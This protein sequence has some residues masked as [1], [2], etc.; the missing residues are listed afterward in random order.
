MTEKR[1]VG[2]PRTTVNDLPDN[3][4]EIMRECGQEGGTGVECRALL[5]IGE[6]AWYTLMDDSEEF[7]EMDAVRKTLSEVWW[8]RRGREM[9]MGEDGNATVWIFSMKNMF[10]WR[11]KQDVDHTSGGKPVQSFDASK[12][13]DAALEELMRARNAGNDE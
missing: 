3:W 1:K 5:G 4:R 13:S 11:D 9:A 7:R 10:G 12:L 6:S 2:R 8:Q